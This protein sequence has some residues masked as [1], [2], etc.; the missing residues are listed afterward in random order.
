M[1]ATPSQ[2]TAGYPS[3]LHG[4]EL[5]CTACHRP[6]RPAPLRWRCDCGSP[7][8]LD[9]EP[10]F[11]LEQI[12]RSAPSMWRYR[13]AL[14]PFDDDH[15]V[16]LGEG[17]TP[18][19]SVDLDGRPVLAKLDYLFPSG[20][21][22][23]RGASLLLSHA[24]SLGVERIIEDSSGNAGASI[25]AYAA[26]AGIACRI[27]VPE[28]T[29][30]DK[31]AQIRCFGAELERVPGDRDATA[32][33]AMAE[34]DH[35]FYASHVWNPIFFQGTK[36]FAYELCEQLDWMPPHVLVL[37][38]GNGTLLLGAAIGFSD[39]RR[40][41]VI[42]HTPRLIGVQAANCAPLVHAMERG[43]PDPV[44]ID[45]RS[46]MAEGIAIPTPARGRQMIA[47]VRASGGR[48]VAVAEAEIRSALLLM[49]RQGLD[50]EPTT[51]A[52]VAGARR[53]TS[54]FSRD[55]VVAVALTGHGLK[56]AAKRDCG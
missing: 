11:R 4:M 40:S 27:L 32:D 10:H 31:V 56:A 15:V 6:Y 5:I 14:P 53:C 42:P 17:F 18:L 48:I 35:A 30:P 23:D 20:S 9:F 45:A 38:A 29:S 52:I 13:A 12:D 7:L 46:T 3:E 21:Y 26:R 37:P 55:D 50:V 34:A 41:G 43:A 44:G 1:T 19:T 54:E 33:A 47:A 2:Q 8:D 24:R 36:T 49:Q 28:A 51:A 39:L 16:S 22:K 25:A